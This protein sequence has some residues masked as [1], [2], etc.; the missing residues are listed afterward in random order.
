MVSKTGSLESGAK[1]VDSDRGSPTV[2]SRGK[3]TDE[4]SPPTFSRGKGTE[5]KRSLSL[6]S[7][8]RAPPP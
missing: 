7:L 1:K 8:D 6:I 4:G 3:G 5:R 2:F